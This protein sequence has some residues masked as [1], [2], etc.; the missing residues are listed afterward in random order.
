MQNPSFLHK[1]TRIWSNHAGAVAKFTWLVTIEALGFMTFRLQ[2]ECNPY[3]SQEKLREFCKQKEIVIMAY[4]PLYAPN[5]LGSNNHG[6][7]L[8][9]EPIIKNIAEKYKKTPSQVVLRY[10][11]SPALQVLGKP[12]IASTW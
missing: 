8:F 5:R 4:S 3:F 9:Q 1:V 2:V 10:L 6:L 7:N 11:V 12:C